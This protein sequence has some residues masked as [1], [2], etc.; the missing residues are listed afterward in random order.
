MLRGVG[1]CMIAVMRALSLL[2]VLVVASAATAG[3]RPLVIPIDGV[4]AESIEGAASRRGLEVA[5]PQPE[6]DVAAESALSEVRPLYRDMAF[7][8]A[9]ARVQ[10][11]EQALVEARM[12]TPRVAAAL[13]ELEI[14]LGACLLLDNKV[15]DAVEHFALAR[16]LAPKLRPDR[17][18]PP[19]VPA[20]FARAAPGARVTPRIALSPP[21][22]RLWIDGRPAEATT[23]AGVHWILVERADR[24][25]VGRVMRMTQAAPEIAVNLADAAAPAEAL[26]QAEARLGVGPLTP[27]EALAVSAALARTLWVVGP[28][29]ADRYSAGDVANPARHITI[30]GDPIAAV[31]AAE[32]L[33]LAPPVPH[34]PIYKRAALWVP[35]GAAVLLAVGAGVLAG[36]L[37]N[38]S[39]DY[40]ARVH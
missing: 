24:K 28:G 1:R 26:R 23:T 19:E 25:P 27:D 13:A 12:P 3:E 38:A 36:T 34:K 18:F 4:S 9:A 11:A 7:A 33:C 40:V 6:P 2:T 20:A 31:C 22:A 17:I 35:I 21:D 30:A 5:R 10:T 37:A 32:P 14:W 29:A 8:R 15:A 16:T 39:S